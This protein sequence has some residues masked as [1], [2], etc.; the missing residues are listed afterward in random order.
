MEDVNKLFGRV[1]LQKVRTCKVEALGAEQDAYI[2]KLNNGTTDKIA[3][4][5]MVPHTGS[6][7][8]MAPLAELN[9]TSLHVRSYSSTS[10]L[11]TS[12]ASVAE[13]VVVNALSVQKIASPNWGDKPDVE[14]HAIKV[15]SSAT[16]Y[17]SHNPLGF[18]VTLHSVYKD[19]KHGS[20]LEN[21]IELIPAL[22]T[23]NFTLVRN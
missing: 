18:N 19:N 16:T 14:L 1:Q 21:E 17:G 22:L 20:E 8:P 10:T 15:A 23:Y 9:W 13:K 3:V 7:L 5:A 2:A 4:I 11:E 12:L 6:G